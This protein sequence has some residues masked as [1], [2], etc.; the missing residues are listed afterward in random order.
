MSSLEA[1]LFVL[2]AE[3][4]RC[5]ELGLTVAPAPRFGIQILEHDRVIGIW[6]ERDGILV[7]RN[8]AS[9]HSRARADTAVEALAATIDMAERQQ[10]LG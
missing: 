6:S 4:Q 7:F 8:L 9:W 3:S 2:I 1:R 10:W 5:T